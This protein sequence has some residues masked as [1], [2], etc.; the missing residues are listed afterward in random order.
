MHWRATATLEYQTMTWAEIRATPTTVES[1]PSG[2]KGVSESTLRA[3]QILQKVK[4][5]LSRGVP[6]DVLLELIA[7]AEKAVK[8]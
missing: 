1:I 2:C 4:D 3:W 5:Y 6:A 7:E 8:P